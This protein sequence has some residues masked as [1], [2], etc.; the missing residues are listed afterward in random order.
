M[1]KLDAIRQSS[2]SVIANAKSARKQYDAVWNNA[3]RAPM[4]CKITKKTMPDGKVK[5]LYRTSRLIGAHAY[6]VAASGAAAHAA[7]TM[8]GDCQLVREEYQ[9]ESS[10]APWMP[11]V[12]KGA[13]M[14]LEQFLCALAQEAGTKA[15]A[16]RQGAGSTKR[17]NRKHMQMGWDAVFDS[18]FSASAIMPRSMY[19]A[20]LAKSTTKKKTGK[21]EGK[22]QEADA[23][24]EDYSPPEDEAA[25]DDA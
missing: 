10:R 21:A 20:T 24:D 17:L 1:V 11:T 14:V 6:M 18:V 9:K 23:D 13:K 3:A 16:V 12:S 5:K 25:A 15:H 22:T 7:R 19:V 4:F 2:N 8:E